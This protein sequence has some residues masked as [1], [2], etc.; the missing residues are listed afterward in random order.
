[1]AN[2]WYTKKVNNNNNNK[3]NNITDIT[4]IIN[5]YTWSSIILQSGLQS[6]LYKNVTTSDVVQRKGFVTNLG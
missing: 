5:H 4:G 6:V 1:M 3:T 2:R